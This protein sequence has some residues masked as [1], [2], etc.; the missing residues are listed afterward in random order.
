MLR[1]GDELLEVNGISVMGKRTDEI[2]RLMV[3][4][5]RFEDNLVV[6][7]KLPFAHTYIHGCCCCCFAVR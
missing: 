6:I 7:S 3:R 1:E 4:D 2:I 5:G